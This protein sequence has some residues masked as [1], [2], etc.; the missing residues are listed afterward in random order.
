MICN[1][2]R[3][4]EKLDRKIDNAE[5]SC[6]EAP[7]NLRPGLYRK[8]GELSAERDRLKS[9]LDALASSRETRSNRKDDTEIDQAFDALRNLG[10]GETTHDTPSSGVPRL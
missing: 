5:D 7:S 8:L 6:L 4:I 3:E 10:T 1:V 2:R 9:E